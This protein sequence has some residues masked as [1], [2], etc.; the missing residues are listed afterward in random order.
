MSDMR[1]IYIC[2]NKT[3][4]S[5]SLLELLKWSTFNMVCELSTDDLSVNKRFF[6]INFIFYKC[7]IWSNQRLI[8]ALYQYNHWPGNKKISLLRHLWKYYSI[9]NPNQYEKTILVQD[10]TNSG[11]IQFCI[12]LRRWFSSLYLC[13]LRGTMFCG[14]IHLGYPKDTENMNRLEGYNWICTLTTYNYE[15]CLLLL[16]MV[17]VSL[18]MTVVIV[19]H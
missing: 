12:F 11:C 9:L 6:I 8:C 4:C 17:Y 2:K 14:G 7:L 5:K 15:L 3:E 19:Q 16:T 13:I 10:T 1:S 18:Q